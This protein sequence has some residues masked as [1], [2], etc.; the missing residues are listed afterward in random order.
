MRLACQKCIFIC[1]KD[2]DGSGKQGHKQSVQ[3]LGAVLLMIISQIIK[4]NLYENGTV[5]QARPSE[6]VLGLIPGWGIRFID[7]LFLHRR[8]EC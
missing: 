2:E 5:L 8:F 4:C 3:K 1:N 6:L 7:F